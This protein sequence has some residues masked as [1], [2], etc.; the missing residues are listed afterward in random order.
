MG[1]GTQGIGLGWLDAKPEIYATEERL[2]IAAAGD[3]D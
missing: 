3:A 1:A 2:E